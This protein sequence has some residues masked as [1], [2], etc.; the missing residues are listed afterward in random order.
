M[1]GWAQQGLK[2]TAMT[3]LLDNPDEGPPDTGGASTWKQQYGL[4]S[5]YVV[6]DPAFSLISG[7]SA[8]TPQI[9][10]VD[11]RT[12]EVLHVSSGYSGSYPSIL[13]TLALQNQ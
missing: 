7:G 6:A 1:T 9:T 11:P 13:E 8:A 2:I 10:I 4:T 5:I 12:M 3:L